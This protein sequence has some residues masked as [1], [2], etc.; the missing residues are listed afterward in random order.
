MADA[1]RE[2]SIAEEKISISVVI[3]CYN[4]SEYVATAIESALTQSFPAVDVVV[5][6]N[7]SEDDS[8]RVIGQY[9]GR[10][11]IVNIRPN[12]GVSVARNQGAAIA[13]GNWYLFLDADDY[14]N[15]G[16]LEALSKT[17]LKGGGG[18]V[19]FGGIT[20]YDIERK[21][22]SRRDS[23]DSAGRPPHPAVRGFWRSAI[24]TPGA[25]MVHCSVHDAIGGFEKP[26]QPTEDRD[27]WMKCG[28]TTSFEYCDYSVLMKLRR[29][30]SMRVYSRWAPLWGMRV[31]LEFLVWCKERRIQ[32]D[33]SGVSKMNIVNHA[34]TR[35]VNNGDEDIIDQI[36]Q[37]CHDYGINNFELRKKV[38]MARI[39]KYL[40]RKE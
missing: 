28:V 22:Y 38:L 1:W 35:A 12:K 19:V 23:P 30:E 11:K 37:Y 2:I 16:A 14:L 36:M 25:A 31:Q 21:E 29:P 27:Y 9:N 15:N 20:Q 7:G 17:V 10:V 8:A 39:R 40:R 33:F 26:W 18:G 34:I 4:L 24:G 3:P 32:T 5:V 13:T 6:D